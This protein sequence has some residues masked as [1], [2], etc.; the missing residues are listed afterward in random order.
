MGYSCEKGKTDEALG[1]LYKQSSLDK[2]VGSF[3]L[4]YLESSVPDWR[5]PAMGLTSPDEVVN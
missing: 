1:T 5:H 4:R 2:G 3:G